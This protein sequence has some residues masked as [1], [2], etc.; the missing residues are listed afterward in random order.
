MANTSPPAER[1]R[2]GARAISAANDSRRVRS[3]GRAKR[4]ALASA[5]WAALPPATFVAIIL[6]WA[7]AVE[8]FAIPSYLLPSPLAVLN[9]MI[10]ERDNLIAQAL[11]TLKALG[12]GLLLCLAIGIPIGLLIALSKVA[13]QTV[14][15][16][17]MLTQLVPKIAIAPLLVV[18][19]GFS[20][21]TKVTLV[22]LIAFFPLLMSSIAA[23]VSLDDRLLYL[24]R[25]MG[26][27]RFQTF[28][29]LRLPAALPI[30]FSGIKTCATI[31]ITGA[32]VAE[33]LG[34][35]E[36][37]GYALL[38][39]SSQLDTEYIF[40]ILVV[41]TIIG[42]AINYLIEALEW[43]LTPWE[44]RQKSGKK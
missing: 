13:K 19:L 17:V 37:L 25:S 18:W 8:V 10:A 20:V 31:A 21:Q 39:A 1:S 12:I 3:G 11:P 9:R 35:N 36:G 6:L 4:Q 23:F 26:A 27:T 24:T 28:W 5:G 43:W 34:S 15:P 16:V 42:I 38:R 40:A 14:Y 32:L 7:A 29:N 30:I 2:P 41:L 44:R 22:V 33:F